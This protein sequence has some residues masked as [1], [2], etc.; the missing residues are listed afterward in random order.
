M[1]SSGIV[2]VRP[3]HIQAGIANEP[4]SMRS[5]S[6]ARQPNH[7]HAVCV[8]LVTRDLP[9]KFSGAGKN[10]M[11]VAP[12]LRE[13][14]LQPC[15]VGQSDGTG[16]QSGEYEGISILGL[17][18]L[19]DWKGKLKWVYMFIKEFRASNPVPEL[20]RFRGYNIAYAAVIAIIRLLRLP[21]KIIVQPACMDV[22][23]PDAIKGKRLGRWQLRQ[24]LRS[25]AVFAMNP[26]IAG[27]FLARNYKKG[28]IYPV[29]NPVDTVKFKPVDAEVKS[30]LRGM[31]GL[32]DGFLIITVGIFEPRKRQ[33]FVTEAFALGAKGY[34]DVSLVHIGPTFADLERL[35]RTDKLGDALQE[36]TSVSGVIKQYG[37]ENYVQCI[38]HRDDVDKY[39][40]AADAFVHASI[41]EGE[42][43]VVNEALS[44]GLATVL[45]LNAI[46]E[47]QVS[48]DCVAWFNESEGVSGLSVIIKK[49]ID[50]RNYVSSL[51][52]KGR[53]HIM[54][55]RRLDAAANNYA[56][57]LISV[58]KADPETV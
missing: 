31:L 47:A 8:W 19:D 25:D 20:I 21:V 3:A 4:E 10:D 9:P 41:S 27:E 12:L 6:P 37:I 22:D 33:S 49:L 53:E 11:L 32:P 57:N 23:N 13:S 50:D 7:D 55:T 35:G 18:R 38:G 5:A 56:N 44:S 1:K 48:D 45:P 16:R 40:S 2:P 39:M 34:S 26:V 58:F 43:N 30:S 17:G 46:Y 54:L 15:F 52:A 51:G 24:M 29:R 36:M 42:A 28:R 14:G